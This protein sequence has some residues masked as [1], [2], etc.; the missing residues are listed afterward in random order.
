[1]QTQIW[2]QSASAL[3]TKRKKNKTQTETESGSER[4][5]WKWQENSNHKLGIYLRS[6]NAYHLKCARLPPKNQ[7][8]E[9]AQPSE[10]VDVW[11]GGGMTEW[12]VGGGRT[13]EQK[14]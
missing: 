3:E 6:V 13:R 5:K 1:M 8:L 9:K 14:E 11:G 4:G 2:I 10:W 7:L 12:V